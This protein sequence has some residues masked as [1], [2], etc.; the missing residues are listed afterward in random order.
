MNDVLLAALIS[1]GL[2]LLGSVVNAMF[3]SRM[4]TKRLRAR[5]DEA[6]AERADWYRRSLFERRLAA[7]QKAHG[8]VLEIYRAVNLVVSVGAA[9]DSEEASELRSIATEARAWYDDDSVYLYDELPESSGFVGFTNTALMVARGRHVDDIWDRHSEIDSVL[10]D[11]AREL[12]AVATPLSSTKPM[13]M[14]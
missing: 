13:K 8:W 6:R 7:V 1:G 5:A 9:P 14:C 3:N 2:V 4:E 10:R 11:R 12:F